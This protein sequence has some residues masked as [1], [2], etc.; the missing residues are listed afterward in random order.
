VLG[1]IPASEDKTP[2]EVLR[3]RLADADPERYGE[4]TTDQLTA[5]LRSYEIDTAVQVH[6]LAGDGQRRNRRG[7]T[8]Q[9][10]A[11]VAAERYRRRGL[12]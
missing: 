7:I 5:R 9:S 6:R 8:R 4:L 1:V 2:A 11:E 3:E 12:Q 10:V